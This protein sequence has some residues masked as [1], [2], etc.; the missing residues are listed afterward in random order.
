MRPV[1]GA[2]GRRALQLIRGFYKAAR[3]GGITEFQEAQTMYLAGFADEAAA[4]IDGQIKALKE[5]GWSHIEPRNIDGVNLV[6]L[7]DSRFEEVC[8]KLSDAAI[9]VNCFGSAVA[10]WSRKLSD[11]PDSSY[12]ELKRAIPRMQRLGARLIRV[13]SFATDEDSPVSDEKAFGEV[14][15]RMKTLAE[16]A[17]DAGVTCVH[18]NCDTWAGQSWEHTLRLVDAVR[19]PGLKLVFDTGNPVSLKD[20]RGDPPYGF[21]DSW[22]FYQ[23]VKEHVVHVHIKDAVY[24]EG[25]TRYTYPGQGGGCVKEILADLHRRGYDG[26]L[27]IE[28]HVAVVVHDASVQS[29]DSARFDAFVEYGRRTERLVRETGWNDFD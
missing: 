8:G 15:N 3:T 5:L 14:A 24:E 7:P 1:D 26:G 11:P 6:D 10:N 4:G 18:E 12:D 16:I 28:P 9:T 29:E 17:A 13:M 2:E 20:V 27:S 22:D 23:A 19:S 25:G 21:Q